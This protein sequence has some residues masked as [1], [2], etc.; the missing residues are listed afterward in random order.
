MFKYD[1]YTEEQAMA[2]RFQLMKEG[3]YDAVVTASQDT[4]SKTGNAMMDI[5]LSVYDESGKTHDI[6]DFLVFTKGMM[7]KVVHFADSAGIMKEY[8]EG[9]LCSET[10]INK[11]V[12]VKISMEQGREIPEEKLQGKASGSRYPDKNKVEDY[13]KNE[14]KKIELNPELDDDIPF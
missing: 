8:E 5:T 13:V 11:S 12:K 2:G 3:V 14:D 4:Q 10:A 7:W 9:K 1:V 6:R